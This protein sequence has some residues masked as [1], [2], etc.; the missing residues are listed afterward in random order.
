MAARVRD[1]VPARRLRVLQL[2]LWPLAAAHPEDSLRALLTRTGTA[3]VHRLGATLRLGLVL[4]L[5]NLL[6]LAAAVMPFLTLTIAYSF[7][8]AAHFALAPERLR[9]V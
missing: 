6:G 2:H 9:E 1:R 8:A 4:L 5:V 7:L 3:L